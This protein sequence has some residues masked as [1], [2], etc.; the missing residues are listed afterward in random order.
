MADEIMT[1]EKARK[2]VKDYN[3][4]VLTISLKRDGVLKMCQ[5]ADMICTRG[6]VVKTDLLQS[7]VTVYNSVDTVEGLSDEDKGF[8]R[9]EWLIE[10]D[11]GAI[12]YFRVMGM[13]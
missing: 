1:V 9:E 5:R 4:K 13:Y 7:R 2:L 12:N 10:Q 8:L 3:E 11:E 6:T